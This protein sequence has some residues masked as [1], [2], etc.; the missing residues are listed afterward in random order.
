MNKDANVGLNF[1]SYFA[2]YEQLICGQE[3]QELDLEVDELEE[4]YT[5]YGDI[6]RNSD[7]RITQKDM[8]YGSNT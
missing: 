5:G 2:Y 1:D 4:A 7:V 6:V 8:D 3:N